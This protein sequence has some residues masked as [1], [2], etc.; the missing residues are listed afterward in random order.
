M[1][2]TIIV[3]DSDE[4]PNIIHVDEEPNVTHVDEEDQEIITGPHID[5]NKEW[6]FINWE[7]EVTCDESGNNSRLVG[8]LSS[9]PDLLAE[10]N[11]E[12]PSSNSVGVET[13]GC[14]SSKPLEAISIP[15]ISIDDEDAG[16]H[17]IPISSEEEESRPRRKKRAAAIKAT[18]VGFKEVYGSNF[19][20]S[21]SDESYIQ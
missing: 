8:P 12:S 14:S 11:Q 1:S 15:I 2:R 7:D 9:Y 3:I 18:T 21:S 20:D 6:P 5:L 10:M 19:Q 17:S 13:S 4:E 16:Q